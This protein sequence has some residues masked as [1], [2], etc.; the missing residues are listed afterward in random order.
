MLV[1]RLVLPM[2]AAFGGL[3]VFRQDSG[4]SDCI[5]PV[6]G[7]DLCQDKTHASLLPH[8]AV[9]IYLASKS[10]CQMDLAPPM[11]AVCTL[12]LPSH[13]PLHMSVPFIICTCLPL[14]ACAPSACLPQTP[15]PFPHK[16][17]AQL[18][19]SKMWL[20]RW[21]VWQLWLRCRRSWW[22]R[23]QRLGLASPCPLPHSSAAR[24]TMCAA[25]QPTSVPEKRLT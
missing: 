2:A 1:G 13:Q 22:R 21:R 3:E 16:H 25:C 8:K 23:L 11:Q 17:L 5:F 20:Y 10:C 4:S 18:A 15:P 19:F 14:S 6:P 7:Q 24:M 9:E 12:Q